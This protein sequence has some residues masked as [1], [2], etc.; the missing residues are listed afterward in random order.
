MKCKKLG[1][2]NPLGIGRGGKRE[3]R[4]EGREGGG[5]E[6]RKEINKGREGEERKDR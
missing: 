6:E 3:E 4:V 2:G 1:P 5:R